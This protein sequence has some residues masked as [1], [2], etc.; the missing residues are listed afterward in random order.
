MNVQEC[1]P[2]V[3]LMQIYIDIGDYGPNHNKELIKI[4]IGV[5]FLGYLYDGVVVSI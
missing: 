4:N 2:E 5:Y 3:N 1:S